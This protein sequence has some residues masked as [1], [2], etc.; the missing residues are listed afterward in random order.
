RSPVAGVDLRLQRRHDR[1]LLLRRRPDR[2]DVVGPVVLLEPPDHQPVALRL[3]DLAGLRHG[4][5]TFSTKWEAL[6]PRHAEPSGRPYP[7]VGKSRRDLS[8]NRHRQVRFL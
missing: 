2:H 8:L 4:P 3:L 6:T 1:G 5:P 7:P